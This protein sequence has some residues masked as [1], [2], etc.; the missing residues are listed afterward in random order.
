MGGRINQDIDAGSPRFG[1][2]Q[3][4]VRILDHHDRRIDHGADRNRDA[5]EAHDIGAQP[6]QLH[7]AERHQHANRQHQDRD[8]RAAEVQEEHDANECYDDT[9]L[10][11]RMLE[12]VDGGVDQVRAIVHRHDLHRF[13]QAG[14]DLLEALLDVLDDVERVD[15]ETLQHDAAG[16]FALAVQFGDAAPLVRTELDAGDIAQQHRRAAIGLEHDVAEIVDA[17]QI[18]LAADD[19][20]EFREFDGPPP[21]VGIAGADRITH[22]RHGDAEI[23]HALRVEDDVVLFE[24]SADTCDLGHA[25]GLGERELQIPVLDGAGVGKIELLRHHR[26]LV[27]PSHAGRIRADG[28]RHASG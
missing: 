15:A 14:C 8:Q 21:D 9:F 5:A 28:R 22:L 1:A 19:V 18:A 13:R 26:V 4:L 2:L 12:R 23:A 3:V 24:E 25:F 27:N 6:Q 20:F 17:L 16:D 7:R 10:K 11:Q